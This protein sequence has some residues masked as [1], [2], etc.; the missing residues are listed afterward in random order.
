MIQR[1]K[2][3]IKEHI[4]HGLTLLIGGGALIAALG[5]FL[6]AVM[7]P[8]VIEKYSSKPATAEQIAQEN[9]CTKQNLKSKHVKSVIYEDDIIRAREG[10]YGKSIEIKENQKKAL[11]M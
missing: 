7:F 1:Q 4:I 5:Y 3:S 2:Y 8:K 10:C 11:E 6:V 9:N